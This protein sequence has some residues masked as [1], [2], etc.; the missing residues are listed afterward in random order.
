MR[1]VLLTFI[2]FLAYVFTYAQEY[3]I[4][5]AGTGKQGE[6]LVNVVVSTKKKPAKDAENFVKQ[7][8]VHGVIFRG[9][10]AVGH[11]SGQKPIV[12]DPNIEQTKAE[13][14]NAFWKICFYNRIFTCCDE[15]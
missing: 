1:K 7:Y 3:T 5:S 11:Y 10:M 13:F 2:F 9:L 12:S 4:S 8:A 14:F 6:Y 15:E